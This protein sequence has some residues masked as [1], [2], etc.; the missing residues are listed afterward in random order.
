MHAYVRTFMKIEKE[1]GPPLTLHKNRWRGPWR[2]FSSEIK[3]S[4][5]ASTIGDADSVDG[6]CAWDSNRGGVA[7]IAWQAGGATASVCEGAA[8]A[9][10]A[11]AGRRRA[12]QSAIRT[13]RT[14]DAG[15][16]RSCANCPK[17]L[18]RSTC[19]TSVFA[20]H[21]C[22]R[23]CGASCASG[24]RRRPYC[25]AVRPRLAARADRSR[26]RIHIAV[27]PR[28]ARR[29]RGPRHAV[30]AGG[31]GLAVWAGAGRALGGGRGQERK[32]H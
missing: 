31:T 26:S 13:R 30:R 18:A 5:G 24:R 27:R 22:I 20:F 2:K 17:V 12:S 29:A 6:G 15:K 11:R 3:N 32:Q 9:R 28:P 10:N 1:T 19:G 14:A 23:A 25:V 21:V 16:G 8:G 7:R 4:S